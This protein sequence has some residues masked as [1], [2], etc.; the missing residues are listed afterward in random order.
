MIQ[1]LDDNI[2]VPVG[3]PGGISRK[4]GSEGPP[5]FAPLL[6]PL[7]NCSGLG[8]VRRQGSFYEQAF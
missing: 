8:T 2:A 4:V 6:G 5:G 3:K 7:G 1:H